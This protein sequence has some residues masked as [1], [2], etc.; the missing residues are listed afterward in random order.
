MPKRPLND[1]LDQNLLKNLLYTIYCMTS[2]IWFI[3]YVNVHFMLLV[4]FQDWRT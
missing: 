1:Q 4:I 2:V 3:V